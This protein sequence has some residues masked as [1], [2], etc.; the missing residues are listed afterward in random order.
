MK[1]K[2]GSDWAQSASADIIG[3]LVK[4]IKFAKGKGLNPSSLYQSGRTLQDLL[5]EQISSL[6][7]LYRKRTV[8][9]RPRFDRRQHMLAKQLG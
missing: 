6:C 4:L 5:A 8:I 9:A 1:Q 2:T 7:F 3:D